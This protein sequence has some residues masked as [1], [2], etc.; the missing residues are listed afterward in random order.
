MY[1]L[2]FTGLLN[3]LL[4]L[5]FVLALDMTVA[6]VAIATAASNLVSAVILFVLL[7]KETGDCKISLVGTCIFRVVWI[8]TVFEYFKTLESIYVSY[9]ITWIL[10]TST[11]LA[12]IAYVLRK[13]IKNQ[14]GKAA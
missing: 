11:F 7:T 3:I 14:D 13:E 12:C 6:G 4:N 1:V 8:V 2:A 5:L 9:S 10:T